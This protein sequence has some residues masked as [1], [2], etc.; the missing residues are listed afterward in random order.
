M[1]DEN[2]TVNDV[3]DSLPKREVKLTGKALIG[4]IERLQKERKTHVNKI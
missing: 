2:E 1:S 4:K 3:L